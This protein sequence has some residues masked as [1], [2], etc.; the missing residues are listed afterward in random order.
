M[1]GRG[2][3]VGSNLGATS[4]ENGDGP[5]VAEVRV[6]RYV[7]GCEQVTEV[8][9]SAE[10]TDLPAVWDCG[11]CGRPAV[12][13]GLDPLVAEQVLAAASMTTRNGKP[14]S[15]KTPWEHVLA[16]RSVADLEA[17]LAERLAV[18]RGGMRASA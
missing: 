5:S 13:D 11:S 7:C 9:F 15:G 1:A 10:A 3:V 16:R 14:L 18:L 2:R 6:A 12:A 4:Y 17:I 8:P